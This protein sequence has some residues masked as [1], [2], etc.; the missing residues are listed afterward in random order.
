MCFESD[1]VVSPDLKVEE[2]EVAVSPDRMS[3]DNHSHPSLKESGEKVIPKYISL[4][5]QFLLPTLDD[6]SS[7]EETE[8][9]ELKTEA[10][11]HDMDNEEEMPLVDSE[12]SSLVNTNGLLEFIDTM[13]MDEPENTKQ[14][15]ITVD[16]EQTR[17]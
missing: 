8:I 1:S 9:T 6:S 12:A 4:P 5:S 16:S 2:S 17:T 11:I 10:E 13:D 15:E 14:S 3:T 7:E